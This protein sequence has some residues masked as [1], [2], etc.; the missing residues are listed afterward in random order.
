MNC[1]NVLSWAIPVVRLLIPVDDRVV[2]LLIPV[3]SWSS[4]SSWSLDW[5]NRTLPVIRWRLLNGL[6]PVIRWWLLIPVLSWSSWSL[7][8]LDGSLPF[9]CRRLPFLN[10]LL[11]RSL[12]V[13]RVR[14]L[15]GNC[16]NQA[17]CDDESFKEI[18]NQFKVF[19]LEEAAN[20]SLF[21]AVYEELLSPIKSIK[22][23]QL[24]R[25]LIVPYIVPKPP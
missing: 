14:D 18:R 15:S 3:V 11:N 16:R 13:P 9:I 8:W 25:S 22:N 4:W 5:L 2:W 6:L 7:D 20:F 24:K 12:P 23:K 21:I 10:G 19:K 1:D 17:E